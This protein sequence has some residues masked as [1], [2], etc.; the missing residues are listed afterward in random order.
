MQDPEKDRSQEQQT[1]STRRFRVWRNPSS[2]SRRS[3][4]GAGRDGRAIISRT[5]AGRATMKD[6]NAEHIETPESEILKMMKL[7]SFEIE[8]DIACLSY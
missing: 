7:G 4:N 8:L 5:S 2:K 1:D 6:E 3:D